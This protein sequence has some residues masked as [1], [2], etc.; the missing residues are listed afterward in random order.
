[1]DTPHVFVTGTDT[2]AGKTVVAAALLTI[3][4]SR[5][6][7]VVPM[8]PIQTGCSCDESGELV[9]PDVQFCLKMAGMKM[10]EPELH[11]LEVYKFKPACSPHLAA[12]QAGIQIDIQSILDAA[13][14]L[15]RQHDGL[16]LEGAGG[17]L[18][19][20][21]GR[22]T[23]LDLMRSLELPVIL[24]TRPELGTI[25]HT[26][27]SLDKLRQAGLHVAGVVMC[28][29]QPTKWG[30]IEQSNLETIKCLGATR[31]LGS[32]PYIHGL[33]EGR[34]TAEEFLRTVQEYLI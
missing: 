2:D 15:K 8:K 7:D 20:I 28:Q 21:A 34:L 31:L 14:K 33:C 12:A 11:M 1:M 16:I 10:L 23:M 3:W 9:G 6:L 30:M 25:N 18:V 26:L 29:T 17:V 22:L 27:L 19:P 13:E 4:R 5:G 32:I 24:V